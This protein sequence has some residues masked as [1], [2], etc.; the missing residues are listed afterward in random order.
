MLSSGPSP[1]PAAAQPSRRS[2]GRLRSGA[3][4]EYNLITPWSYEAEMTQMAERV[5]TGLRSTPMIAGAIPLIDVAG[6]L[7]GDREA[8]RK[9]AA[10][11]RWAFENVGF[12]YL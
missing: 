3:R 5:A 9:A 6:H 4:S 11:L 8:S 1:P 10:Q 7:G 2:A 12:Y